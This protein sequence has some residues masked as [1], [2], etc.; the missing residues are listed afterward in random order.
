MATTSVK[1]RRG[2]VGEDAGEDDVETRGDVGEVDG[3]GDKA[4]VTEAAALRESD[5]KGLG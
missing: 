5:D 1:D 4:N 2:P 3:D